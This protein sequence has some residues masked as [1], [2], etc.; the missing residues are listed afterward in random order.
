MSTK[1]IT[2]EFTKEEQEKEAKALI[3]TIQDDVNALLL[4]LSSIKTAE[5][6]DNFKWDPATTNVLRSYDYGNGD[7]DVDREMSDVKVRLVNLKTALTDIIQDK[8]ILLM[9]FDEYKLSGY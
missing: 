8:N 7:V 4:K 3:A 2:T 5:K 1:T 9:Y 6:I